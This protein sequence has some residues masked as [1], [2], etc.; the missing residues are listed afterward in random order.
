M[1][2]MT[3][4]EADLCCPASGLGNKKPQPEQALT[5]VGR[6]SLRWFRL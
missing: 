6:R 5:V 1:L 2:A 3:H 4:A